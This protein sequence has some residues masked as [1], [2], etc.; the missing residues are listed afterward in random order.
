MNESTQTECPAD[1]PPSFTECSWCRNFSKSALLVRI[2]EQ[3]S[4]FGGSL[5]A[6]ASCRERHS[7]VPVVDQP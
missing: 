5:Y 3:G 7:L 2:I 6:C 4:A 1:S